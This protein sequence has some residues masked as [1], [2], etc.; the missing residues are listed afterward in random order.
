[1]PGEVEC[2]ILDGPDVPGGGQGSDGDDNTTSQKLALAD[3]LDSLATCLNDQDKVL[4]AEA[5]Y[6]KVSKQ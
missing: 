2:A 3:A 1:M 5:V 4:E 6:Q